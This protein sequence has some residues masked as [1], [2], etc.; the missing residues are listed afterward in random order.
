VHVRLDASDCAD[1]IPYFAG[2]WKMFRAGG[3][4]PIPT[5]RLRR[6]DAE[7]E[8]RSSWHVRRGIHLADRADTGPVGF[9]VA[10][11]LVY[12]SLL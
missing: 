5:A 7:K 12:V 9:L 11:H 2:R 8:R 1:T 6:G 4:G 10:C 3:L